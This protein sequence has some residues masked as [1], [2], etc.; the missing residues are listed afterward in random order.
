LITQRLR[1]DGSVVIEP[2]AATLG[3]TAGRRVTVPGID[4]TI[5]AP[6]W[7]F[8]QAEGTIANRSDYVV[9]P[10][11]PDPFYAT[12]YPI[13]EAYWVRTTVG[14]VEREVLAQCFQRR[15]LTY[16]P[17]NPPGWQVEAGNVGRHY[18]AW[19]YGDGDGAGP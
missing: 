16:T 6:F 15:C 5:A 17:D 13:S 11:F 14:G 9:G 12:G 4:H 2:G 18:Y 8:M 7:E 19:R 3:V 1:R 10:L